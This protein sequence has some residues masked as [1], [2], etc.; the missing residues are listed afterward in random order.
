MRVAISYQLVWL[1]GPQ[2][3]LS[4]HT[5]H[6][7]AQLSLSSFELEGLHCYEY[8]EYRMPD[9]FQHSM[10]KNSASHASSSA[11]WDDSGSQLGSQSV[12]QFFV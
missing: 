11:P 4:G 7:W 6:C 10:Y 2:A 1:L 3:G 12:S 8:I 5:N 9:S